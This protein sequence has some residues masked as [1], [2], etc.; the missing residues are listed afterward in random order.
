MEKTEFGLVKPTP[1]T[2]EMK[3]SYLDYAMSVIVTRAIPDVKDGL[4]PVHRRVLY[5]MHKLGLGASS[6][7][8]KTARI[9]GETIGKYHPHGDAA[10]YD[11]LVR[12]AQDFSM[13]YPLIDGQGNFG[14]VDGDPAAAMRYT[15]ARLT[16]ICEELLLD[17]DKNTV[18]FIDNFDGSE[19]EPRVLPAK[20]PNLLINGTDGIAVGMATKIPPH[21]LG[22]VIDAL[23]YLIDSIKITPSSPSSPSQSSFTLDSPTTVGELVKFIHGPDFPTGGAIFDQQAILSAYET[24]RGGILLRGKVEIFESK[25][26]RFQIIITE[27]PYQQ[28]KALLVARIAALINEKKITDVADLRDESDR[29]GIRVVLDLKASANPQKILNQL[30]RFT[31]LAQMY[32]F[33]LVTLVDDTPKTLNLK[34]ILLEYLKHRQTVVV[35]RAQFELEKA[36]SREHIL[37]GYK[38]ALNNLDEV[39]KTI[40]QAANQETAKQQLVKK[41]KLTEIQ[42]QAI[43]DLQLKRLTA[44]DRQQILDELKAMQKLIQELSE[45]ISSP[46]KIM[47]LIKK[48]LL[49]LKGKYADQRRTQVVKGRPGEVAV[50]DLIKVEPVIITLSRGGYIKRCPINTYRAQGRGGK[51]VAGSALKEEDIISDILTASTH[52]EIL[53]FTNKGRVF[54]CRVYDIPEAGRTARGQALVN[55]IGLEQNEKVSS[56]LTMGEP[57]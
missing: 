25:K 16:R 26:G 7:Y 57:S 14:S 51:G 4:K 30:Y 21:N 8:K 17:L 19:R 32:H 43:L 42:A 46:Q 27:L 56:V 55:L 31:P 33:N 36:K 45:L 49:E 18:N 13:R 34:Q 22:E 10:V 35:R 1:I 24:G 11:T 39:I 48:E 52:D 5:A 38:I 3:R 41:F 37:Q 23:G 47:A 50:E 29:E 20:L 40:R 53:F 28:N 9:V 15:E 44:L 6:S 54:S 2:E 12:L